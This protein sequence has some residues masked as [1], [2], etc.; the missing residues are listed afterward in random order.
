MSVEIGDAD[1]LSDGLLLGFSRFFTGIITII[2]TLA[3]MF[4]VNPIIALV[5]AVL[6][7]VSLLTAK[8]ITGR[9]YG[10]FKEQSKLTGRQSALVEETLSNLPTVKAYVTES[11]FSERFDEINDELKERSFKA[12]FFSSLTN[13]TTRCI[14][15]LVYAAVA[16]TG[17]LLKVNGAT[18][19][20]GNNRRR[21]TFSSQLRQQ[22]H[23]AVQRDN[24][25]NHRTHGGE[26]LRGEIVRDF[27][28]KRRG[29]SGKRK[30]NRAA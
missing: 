17:A 3:F 26:G 25:G 24:G 8:F 6:T 15:A 22:I 21:H 27:R 13:P 18:G 9:T 16:L 10:L 19:A 28:R 12:V 30:E 14:N 29:N 2:G 20:L 11:A 1:K 5:V 7:P 23:K 4:A